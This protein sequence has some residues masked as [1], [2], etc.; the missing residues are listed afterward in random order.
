MTKPKPTPLNYLSQ[1]FEDIGIKG[2]EKLVFLIMCR[3]GNS[4]GVCYMS[5]DKIRLETGLSRSAITRSI[6]RLR[7][8]GRLIRKTSKNK[9][10]TWTYSL[11]PQSQSDLPVRSNRVGGSSQNDVQNL[12]LNQNKNPSL[13]VDKSVNSHRRNRAL[14][15][16]DLTKEF[17]RNIES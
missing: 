9:I 8:A 5:I 14:P 17:K 13:P 6:G 4:S 16:G 12:K 7:K 3:R 10:S 2:S 15:I 11:H 1:A